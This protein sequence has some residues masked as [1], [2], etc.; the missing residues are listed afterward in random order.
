V[1]KETIKPKR[2]YRKYDREFKL[3]AVKL[4][5]ERD[6]P[7]TRVAKDLGIHLSVLRDWLEQYRQ[8]HQNAFPGKGRL[9]PHEQRVKE[10]EEKLKRVEMERDI[11]KKAM[12]YFAK[13]PE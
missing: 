9:K 7:Q 13:A 1:R 10:L 3:E 12:A 11:L 6:M 4:V 2:P 5:M 8:D